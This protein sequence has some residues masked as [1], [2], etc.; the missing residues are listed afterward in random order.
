MLSSLHTKVLE[1]K[2]MVTA[3]LY[4]TASTPTRMFPSVKLSCYV[5]RIPTFYPST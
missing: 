1:R 4:E 5:E 3:L 2:P